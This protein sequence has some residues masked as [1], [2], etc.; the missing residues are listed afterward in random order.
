MIRKVLYYPGSSVA[1]ETGAA[2]SYDRLVI[3][4]LY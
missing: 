4:G 2:D 3:T 1:T